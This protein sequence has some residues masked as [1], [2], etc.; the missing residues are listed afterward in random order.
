M[1]PTDYVVSDIP[2][3]KFL[4]MGVKGGV[5]LAAS[6]L[7]MRTLMAGA[8]AGDLQLPALEARQGDARPRHAQGARRRAATFADVYVENRSSRDILMEEGRFKS[9]QFGISQGAGVRVIVGDKTGYAYTDEITEATLL[10]A[11]DVASYIARDGEAG[12]AGGRQ[13][14]KPA[15]VHRRSSS[16]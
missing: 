12:E 4:E 1:K 15:V 14:G 7:L 8:P 13:G 16:R 5:A 3:R 6:P 2:R 10:R 11:A 9:A